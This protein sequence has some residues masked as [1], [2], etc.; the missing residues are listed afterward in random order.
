LYPQ[1][2][3]S[4]PLTPVIFQSSFFFFFFFILAVLGI[5]LGA[6]YLLGKHSMTWITPSALFILC[7][8]FSK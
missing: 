4:H 5:E 7:W 1:F 3:F 6:S 8:V 2:V